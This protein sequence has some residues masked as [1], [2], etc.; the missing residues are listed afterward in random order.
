MLRPFVVVSDLKR[1]MLDLSAKDGL[2]T[3]VWF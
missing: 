1:G 3:L 2:N